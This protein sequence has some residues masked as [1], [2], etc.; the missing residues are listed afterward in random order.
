MVNI[1]DNTSSRPAA[2]KIAIG[3]SFG[4]VM[5]VIV[6]LFVTMTCSDASA[7]FWNLYGRHL[8][9][10]PANE[11]GDFLA[12]AFA[13]LA[14][15]WLVVTVLVQSQELK[16]QRHELQLTRAE[17]AAT[18]EVAKAQAAEAKKQAE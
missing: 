7:P 9:C 3:I 18:R 1:E 17:F 12:G 5:L 4:W 13:P 2:L 14:F 11:I 16:A 10:M 8:Q 15:F 6:M